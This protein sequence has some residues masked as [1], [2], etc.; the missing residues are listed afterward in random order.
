MRKEIKRAGLLLGLC[1]CLLIGCRQAYTE[2]D[3]VSQIDENSGE[4]AEESVE[5]ENDNSVINVEEKKDE[6]DKASESEERDSGEY[7]ILDEVREEGS[8]M[9]SFYQESLLLEYDFYLPQ[10]ECLNAQAAE[11]IEQWWEKEYDTFMRKMEEQTLLADC[12]C[13][14]RLADPDEERRGWGVPCIYSVSYSVFQSEGVTS[15]LREEYQYYSGGAHGNTAFSGITFDSNTG[16]ELTLDYF[17]DGEENGRIALAQYLI[18]QLD[19]ENLWED[20]KEN[21]VYKIVYE[22]Q[23]Y[24]EDGFI[25][26]LF[27]QYELASYAQGPFFIEVPLDGKREVKDRKAIEK[28]AEDLQIPGQVNHYLVEIAD[29]QT[30][31][32]D[33]DGDGQEEEIFYQKEEPPLENTPEE[34]ITLMIGGKGFRLAVEENIVRESIGLVDIDSEDGKYELAVRATGSSDDYV[35]ALYR[36]DSGEIREIGRMGCIVDRNSTTSGKTYLSGSGSIYGDRVLGIWENRHVN[37]RW[38]LDPETDILALY[39]KENYDYFFD[40]WLEPFV[41][42]RRDHPY[43]LTGEILIYDQMD[44]ASQHLSVTGEDAQII[45]FLSTDGENWVEMELFM[46]G[47]FKRGWMYLEDG[48]IEVREGQFAPC[49]ECINNL[50]GA[51]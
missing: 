27:D 16:E 7:V 1:I 20:Y 32:I 10:V 2:D 9:D 3:H 38:E 11:K 5:D 12:D 37:A 13:L 34:E 31:T 24:V 14:E 19:G 29:G 15:F 26:F 4:T 50:Q 21:I 42:W 36:Y 18:E 22:P 48:Y 25:V 45:Q 40:E 47:E 28:W 51:G 49:Y 17:L 33:L 43:E 41:G 39:E 46:D 23:F 44:R 8:R 35:T 6:A 30:V